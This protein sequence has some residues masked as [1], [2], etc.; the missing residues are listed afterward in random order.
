MLVCG[1]ID[2]LRARSDSQ[3]SVLSKQIQS[4][5]LSPR[6]EPIV[7]NPTSSAEVVEDK[8]TVIIEDLC[9]K[10]KGLER[11][12][13]TERNAVLGL[14]DMVIDLS[15]RIDSSLSTAI[16]SKSAGGHVSG[17]RIN[18]SRERK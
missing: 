16:A 18:I 4:L 3:F 7:H 17:D 13:I 6:T 8:H 2:Q 15:E 5:L 9:G 10:V 11:T 12:I 14:K 1:M